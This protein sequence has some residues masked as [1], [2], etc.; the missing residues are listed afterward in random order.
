MGQEESGTAQRL[1]NKTAYKYLMQY[2]YYVNSCQ[3]VANSN[4]AFEKF[5]GFLKNTFDVQMQNS[6]KQRGN[7]MLKQLQSPKMTTII[8]FAATA[9]VTIIIIITITI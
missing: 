4:F 5:L 2:K 8:E 7:C 1:N 3:H 6:L 9:A